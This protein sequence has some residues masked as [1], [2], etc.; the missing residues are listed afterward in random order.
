[1]CSLSPLAM[2][3]DHAPDR[4]D[5]IERMVAAGDSAA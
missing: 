2:S 4:M 5:E 3:Y 1:M